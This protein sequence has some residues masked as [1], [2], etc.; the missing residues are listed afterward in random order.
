MMY[1][2]LVV[3]FALLIKGADLFVEGSSSVAK[4]LRVPSV[5]IGLTVV[6]FG[7][8]APEA[9][10]SIAAAVTG[11][12]EIA[13]GNVIGSNIFN[14]LMVTGAC[15][16]IMPTMIDKSILYH[17]FPFSI[18]IS[19]VLLLFIAFDHN[20]SRL[21]GIIMLALFGYFLWKTVKTAL[22]SRTAHD[23]EIKTLTPL[24]SGVYILVGLVAIIF[25]GDVVVDSASKIAAVFGLSQTLIGLTIVAMGTSLPELVTSIVASRKGENGLALGNV[26][27]SNIF[28]ILLVLAASATISPIKVSI[29]S[30]YDLLCLIAFSVITWVLARR[31]FKISRPEGILMV[32]L[33]LGYTAYIIVR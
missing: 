22:N 16:A 23:E 1:V 21:D 14:L 33:Y 4:L 11:N 7:T 15:G 17:D 10:V 5:I 27:G 29:L 8:S 26:I 9:A 20:I 12:N 24:R 2:M 32:L 6:A 25:G 28:N 13:V 31:K 3:G 19:A 18:V 30:V